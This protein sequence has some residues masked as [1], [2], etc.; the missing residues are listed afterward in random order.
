LI[1]VLQVQRK[2]PPL[3]GHFLHLVISLIGFHRRP[4]FDPKQFHKYT[5]GCREDHHTKVSASTLL[6][7][8]GGFYKVVMEVDSPRVSEGKQV[9]RVREVSHIVDRNEHLMK[10]RDHT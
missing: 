3:E 10:L 4:L 7:R 9:R 5:P 2:S 6:L 8:E 1:Y